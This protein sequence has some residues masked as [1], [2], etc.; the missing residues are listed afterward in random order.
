MSSPDQ[1]T[2]A[3]V[4]P[5]FP[6]TLGLV[7]YEKNTQVILTLL[8]IFVY[9]FFFLNIVY[10]DNVDFFKEPVFKTVNLF[11]LAIY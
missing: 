3:C 4:D 2:L 10:S 9:D 7:L 6:S 11:S 8:P 5:K 1:S